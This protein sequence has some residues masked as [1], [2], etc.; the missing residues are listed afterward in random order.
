MLK[1]CKY[2]GRIHDSKHR[3]IA[4]PI[5]KSRHTKEHDK[6]FKSYKWQKLR[7]MVL[8]EYPYC[9]RCWSKYK[10]INTDNLQGHHLLSY[11]HYPECALDYLNIAILCGECNN[12]IDATDIVDWE[13]NAE[14]LQYM[15][16]HRG[17]SD[18]ANTTVY[19]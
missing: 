5:N 16:E 7:A 12:E 2:C 1:S 11:A 3:C 15:K 9:E 8:K 19:S 4:M 6:F 18:H 17:A 10:R 13:L 14:R